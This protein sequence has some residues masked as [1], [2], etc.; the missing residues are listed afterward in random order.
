MNSLNTKTKKT[1]LW[2]CA[3]LVWILPIGYFLAF[4]L[5]CYHAEMHGVP[6]WGRFPIWESYRDVDDIEYYVNGKRYNTGIG[7]SFD[8][9]VQGDSV[10]LYYNPKWPACSF[11][12]RR[13]SDKQS[14][15]RLSGKLTNP[16]SWN[17]DYSAMLERLE[18][19]RRSHM[20]KQHLYDLY[21]PFC[22]EGGHD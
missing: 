17:A 5:G 12:P 8:P 21:C 10:L 4:Y 13:N 14:M 11:V 22:K 7:Q 19:R 16:Q 9:I 3:V 6:I 2:A 1:L 15:F 20:N 18:R